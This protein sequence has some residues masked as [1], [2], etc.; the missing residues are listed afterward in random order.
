MFHVPNESR[1]RRGR[2]ASDERDGNNGAFAVKRKGVELFIVASD[3]AP[4]LGINWE[5]VS[6]SLTYRCP[7]WE[8]MCYVKSI[9][10]DAEDAVM[11]LHPR[12]SRYVNHHPYCLHLWRP[13]DCAIPEPPMVAVGPK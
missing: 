8:E 7:T 2:L 4:D 3:G 1:I 12:E 9:F 11:Q 10:W 13:T 5:H 6:V